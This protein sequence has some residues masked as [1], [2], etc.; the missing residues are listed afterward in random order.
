MTG[1]DLLRF[2]VHLGRGATAMTEPEFTGE[3]TWYAAHSEPHTADVS[4]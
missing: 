2:P 3:M 1:I 4:G